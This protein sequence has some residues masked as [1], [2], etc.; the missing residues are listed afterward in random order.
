MATLFRQRWTK[1]GKTR[2]SKKWYGEYTDHK[3]KRVRVPLS[4][5]K[6]A[7]QVMLADL[8]RQAERRRVAPDPFEQ[9]RKTP[10]PDHVEVWERFLADQGAS[11]KHAGQCA[12]RVRR[13]L[14]GWAFASEVQASAVLARVAK[15]TCKVRRKDGKG[16]ERPASQQTRN[17]Y[18]RDAKAFFAWMVRDKRCPDNPL[19]HLTGRTVTV[20][21]HARRALSADELSRLLV[22]ARQSEA[23]YCWLTGEDRYHLYLMAMS[24]GFR[25]GEL[26]ELRPDSFDFAARRVKLPARHDKAKRSVSQPISADVAREMQAY[27][28]GKP[29]DAP[30]WPSS[31]WGTAAEMLRVDLKPAGIPPVVQTAD[32]PLHADFHSLR[33]SYITAVVESGA[34]VKTAQRLARHSSPTLTIGLYAHADEGQAVEAVESLPAYTPAYR[35]LTGT[36][37]ESGPFRTVGE[38][39]AVEGVGSTCGGE[40]DRD[41]VCVG[42]GR[43]APP[44]FEPGMADLQSHSARPGPSEEGQLTAI[45]AGLGLSPALRALVLEL[46]RQ[47]RPAA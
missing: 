29:A 20:R 41:L 11:E 28:R 27:C 35:L 5:D 32:G 30:L 21:H 3:G 12:G 42:F 36:G 46:V 17:Y 7:S 44:G 37:D 15:L 1:D 2:R 14:E 33:H 31:W 10:L 9:H 4:T 18:L 16:A 39:G 40:S 43:E 34:S 25:A 19:S 23:V 6:A 26:A 38:D 13:L 47:S 22:S 24:T 8:M 45:L